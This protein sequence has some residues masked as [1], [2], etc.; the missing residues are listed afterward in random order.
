MDIVPPLDY[1]SIVC[2]CI[3]SIANTGIHVPNIASKLD[4]IWTYD[5]E[6]V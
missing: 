1:L 6:E 5:V 4:A 3:K 2:S